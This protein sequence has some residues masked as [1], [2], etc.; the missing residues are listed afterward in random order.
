MWCGLPLYGSLKRCVGVVVGLCSSIAWGCEG[1][2]AVERDTL[3]AAPRPPLS[4]PWEVSEGSLR[5]EDVQGLG[6]RS[7]WE[8]REVRGLEGIVTAIDESGF[9][10][11][12]DDFDDEAAG[13]TAAPPS[14]ASSAMYV[15]T[16]ERP[17]VLLGDRVRVNGEVVE[18][19]ADCTDYD[20]RGVRCPHLSETQISETRTWVVARGLSLPEPQTLVEREPPMPDAWLPGLGA[21]VEGLRTIEPHHSLVDWYESLERMRVVLPQ[22]VVVQA[23]RGGETVVAAAADV[24]HE[25]GVLRLPSERARVGMGVVRWSIVSSAQGREWN[26]GDRLD[27]GSSGVVGYRFGRYR[28]ELSNSPLPSGLDGF[29]R[30]PVAERATLGDPREHELTVGTWNV[31]ELHGTSPAS[32]HEA[33]A[34]MLVDVL[35]APDVM[36]LQEIGDDS[37]PED[38]GRTSARQTLQRLK[39][40]VRARSATDYLSVALAPDDKLDGGRPGVNIQ[41]ALLY[42]ADR[43]VSYGFANRSQRLTFPDGVAEASRATRFGEGHSAFVGSR[44]PLLVPLSFR[45]MDLWVL[46][47]HLRSKLGDDPLMGRA[48]PPEQHSALQRTEQ[49]TVIGT[50]IQGLRRSPLAAPVLV[51]G[52]INDEE[53][54]KTVEVMESIGLTCLTRWL[55]FADRYSYIYQGR[56]MMLD[57]ALA[58][59]DLAA[60]V[61][62]IDVVHACTEFSRC[63]SDHDPLL[64]RY[65]W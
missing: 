38:D 1:P 5:I 15:Y 56:A 21:P 61:T 16:R 41:S 34:A 18:Y 57:H 64:V 58:T 31:R 4:E 17:S 7:P 3:P 11:Q 59:P 25:R 44:K 12:T 48:N 29:P 53:D 45:G 46:V 39:D 19:R 60:Q 27:A 20:T 35:G 2:V 33:V 28:I 32:R 47:V 55:P 24:Q 23:T 42:R 6:H 10:F 8:G 49:A 30:A 37:G 40:A 54:S 62:G 52:D 63:V 22:V 14:G 43:G 51:V 65:G 36:A 13:D 9:T 26:V 50:W